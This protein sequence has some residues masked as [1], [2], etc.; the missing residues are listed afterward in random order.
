MK[1]LLILLLF[2]TSTRLH[3]HQASTGMWY[4]MSCCHEGDCAEILKEVK[5]PS[6]DMEITTEKGTA[7][8]P[9]G[10]PE[11]SSEDLQSH[12]CFDPTTKRPICLYRGAGA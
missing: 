12:A 10:F 2:V 6:G 1:K 5:L 4:P 7:V 9:K 8:F 11:K 3:A